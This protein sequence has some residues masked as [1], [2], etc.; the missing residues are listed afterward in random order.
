MEAKT[1]NRRLRRTRPVALPYRASSEAP[2]QEPYTKRPYTKRPNTHNRPAPKAGV[3]LSVLFLVIVIVE[4][5]EDPGPPK[6]SSREPYRIPHPV[7]YTRRRRT[8]LAALRGGALLRLRGG[9]AHPRRLTTTSATTPLRLGDTGREHD[10][11][12][13]RCDH[14]KR[15]HHHVSPCA[16]CVRHQFNPPGAGR[17]DV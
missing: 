9:L 3:G 10:R 7:L 5:V 4:V 15:E 8:L 14:G 16:A 13:Q 12:E 6:R 17:G 11:G 2:D 1:K